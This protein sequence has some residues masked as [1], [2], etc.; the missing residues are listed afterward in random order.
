MSRTTRYGRRM[1]SLALAT[2][3]MAIFG[4]RV[5]AQ[6]AAAG[7]TMDDFNALKVSVDTAWV[8]LTGFLVFFMQTG[9]AL[10]ETGMIRHTGAVNALLE[11]FVDAGLTAL[12]WWAVGF[13]IAFGATN[14]F[15]GT[16]LFAPGLDVLSLPMVD[17][18]SNFSWTTI[19]V[20][21][22]FFFQF[23]FAAT[24]ST[25]TTGSMAERT[26]FIGDLLYTAIIAI[27]I[28]PVIV[29]WVWGGG[30]LGANGFLDF[31]GSTVVHTVGGVIAL[32][33]AMLLG[34]RPGRVFGS[35][36]KPHNLAYATL[37]T[38]ILWFGWYGFN[39]GSTLG[40]TGANAP[41]VGIVT[42]NT[43]LA[44]GAA[45]VASLF[46]IFFRTGKWDLA[47]TLNGSLA[48][49]VGIT[50]GCAFVGPFGAIMIGITGGILVVLATDA[51]EMAKVDDAV[52][53]FAVHGACGI[54]GTLAIGLWGD[55]SLMVGVNAG[56]NGLLV[57]GGLD[58]LLTQLVGSAATIAYVTVTAVLMFGF[59][60]AIGRLR[61]HSDADKMGIDA[62]E[63]GASLW[64]DVLPLDNVPAGKTSP[65][66][67]D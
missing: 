3:V 21:T 26:D 52:G 66:I 11:N 33:G 46:F 29:H 50:A 64:P 45:A 65:A 27:V 55:A 15:F 67:G 32:I 6:D 13:G 8:L 20:G 23:A 34:P 56:K 62:Y 19:G 61:V 51:V 47:A 9:F 28:Y 54:M 14:G 43:T 5:L 7:P 53:A 42:L 35:P 38:M 10:L 25:I 18:N 57:G 31:A 44:A 37:G 24:A 41:L 48:G 59:L 4:T 16:T 17:V 12:C 36:P 58:I 30:W 63:H 49:L 2:M 22:M 1:L 39:P 40:I 60:K